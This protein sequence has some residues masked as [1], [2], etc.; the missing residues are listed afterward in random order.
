MLKV[1]KSSRISLNHSSPW[2]M[3]LVFAGGVFAL[4]MGVAG[5]AFA[6][7][8]KKGVK[9]LDAYNFPGRSSSTPFWLVWLIIYPS[10]G[11]ATWLVWRRRK[12]VH[13]YE[14]LLIFAVS[15]VQ[16]FTFWLSQSLRM[17]QIIDGTGLM[18]AMSPPGSIHVTRKL[19]PYGSFPGYFGCH[20]RS[21]SS[22]DG[23]IDSFNR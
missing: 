4:G 3:A 1:H 6:R 2:W 10:M 18:L 16:G 20:S 9:A 12:D 14:P 13:V 23:S 22:W 5:L 11:V 8:R 17:T 15:L 7:T 19:L 21:S